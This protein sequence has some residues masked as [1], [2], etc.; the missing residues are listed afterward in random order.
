[1]PGP[2]SESRFYID[3]T[4]K[5]GRIESTTRD[6]P[7]RT[8]SKARVMVEGRHGGHLPHHSEGDAAARRC[9]D[10]GERGGKATGQTRKHT[11]EMLGSIVTWVN[12]TGGE[13]AEKHQSREP[14]VPQGTGA[15]HD[16]AR[17]STENRYHVVRN[18]L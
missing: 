1:M 11:H 14:Y 7:T 6:P 18:N 2:G 5:D 10:S 8:P 3:W 12:P 17:E 4:A 15:R 9:T 16:G 13:Q